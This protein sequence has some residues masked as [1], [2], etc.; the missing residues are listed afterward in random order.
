MST[1]YSKYC[2]STHYQQGIVVCTSRQQMRLALHVA[3][4]M[5]VNTGHEVG[6]VVSFKSCCTTETVQTYFTHDILQREMMSTILL[7]CY[8]VILD[9]AHERTVAT[10]VLLGALKDVFLSRPGL[11]L[12]IIISLHMSSKCQTYYGSIPL[13]RVEIKHCA[14]V[15]YTCSIQ[16]D[17]FLSALRLLFEIH[18]TKE[19]DDIVIFPACEQK[20]L[21]AY[22]II[23]EGSNLNSDL[24][25]LVPVSLYPS[26]NDIFKPNEVKE[27]RCKNY[28]RKVLLS[29]SFGEF[30]V[31]HTVTFAIYISVERRNVSKV[32][33]PR[34]RLH[35]KRVFSINKSQE[36]MCKQILSTSS[37]GKLFCLYPGFT[38]KE[39]KPCLPARIQESNLTSMVL[40]LKRV[41][42]ASLV[43]RLHKE[44]R[45]GI[46]DGKRE[47]SL[48]N[49]FTSEMIIIYS[50]P[51]W[52]P[53]QHAVTSSP[54]A[55]DVEKWC[56]DYSLSSSALRM[57]EVI[58][59]ELA[60]IVKCIQLPIS[61]PDF[62]SKE[63][64]LSIKKKLSY[65]VTLYKFVELAPQ[66][67]SNLPPSESKES[68]QKV[69]N[70]LS[71]VS[72]MKEEH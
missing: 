5:N 2:L 49:S 35:Y 25:E 4:E 42:L 72:T 9:E 44:A 67:F 17:H 37:S 11:K 18:H 65:L 22:Q 46:H 69:I 66:Y 34:V 40:F 21:K 13:I 43:H 61:E 50:H 57:A 1:Q 29:M 33:S 38:Y 54:S 36:D 56:H 14:E 59:A 3:D 68:L 23:Q 7:S 58:R 70:Y 31:I 20:F 41:D 71:S 64:M 51:V 63:N 6:Y 32:C 52:P 27:K 8:G 28:R 12:V 55:Y 15:V 26:H 60:E 30:L 45:R 39:M 48:T 10:D 16:K 19:R 24:G 53:L 47:R 62:E